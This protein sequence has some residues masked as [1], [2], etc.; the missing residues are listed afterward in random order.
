MGWIACAPLLVGCTH[1]HGNFSVISNKLVRTSDFDLSQLDRTRNVVGEDRM[2][3]LLIFP[4]KLE[5]TLDEAIDD[6]LREGDGD[7]IVDAVVESWEWYVPPYGQAGW[8]V[9][10]DVVKTRRD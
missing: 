9:R 4:T 5:A 8:R 2:H 6:A 1:H 7:L 3:I 10:G